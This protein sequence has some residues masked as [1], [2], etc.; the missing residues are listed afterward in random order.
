MDRGSVSC[1][2]FTPSSSWGFFK[3]FFDFP[4]LQSVTAVQTSEWWI[5]AEQQE[6]FQSGKRGTLSNIFLSILKTDYFIDLITEWI[7]SWPD[8]SGENL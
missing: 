8:T 1:K 2:N 4:Q 7:N 3:N 5:G 6:S